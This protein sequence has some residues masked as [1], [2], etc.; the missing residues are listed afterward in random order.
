MKVPSIASYILTTE[1]SR[2]LQKSLLK[3]AFKEERA[4]QLNALCCT[5]VPCLLTLMKL[6]EHH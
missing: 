3:A 4:E 6:E 5:M 1:S 2:L